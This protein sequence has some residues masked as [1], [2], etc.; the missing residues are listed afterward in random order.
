MMLRAKRARRAKGN[1]AFPGR[2]GVSTSVVVFAVLTHVANISKYLFGNIRK[3][4]IEE[5]AK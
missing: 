5:N 4:E 2:S 3:R 1:S